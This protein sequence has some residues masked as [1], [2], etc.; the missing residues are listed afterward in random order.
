VKFIRIFSEAALHSRLVRIGINT[1]AIILF[2][3]HRKFY[4]AGIRHEFQRK[5]KS[6]LGVLLRVNRTKQPDNP[7]YLIP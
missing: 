3:K 1:A 4:A 7:T 6:K 5:P 2:P